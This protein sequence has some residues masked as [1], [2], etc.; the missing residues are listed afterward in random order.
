MIAIAII[1]GLIAVYFGAWQL[2]E[3]ACPFRY[4]S[5]GTAN[6]SIHLKDI[7]LR[8]LSRSTMW[9]TSE[10]DSCRIGVRKRYRH[11]CESILLVI[12]AELQADMPQAPAMHRELLR[13]GYLSWRISLP[14]RV[15]VQCQCRDSLDDLVSIVHCMIGHACSRPE[16]STFTVHARNGVCGYDMAVNG[17]TTWA[18]VLW[19][20][21]R[22]YEPGRPYKWNQLPNSTL[23]STIGKLV[24]IRRSKG[25]RN[26]SC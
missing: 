10:T 21:K 25:K 9:F 16:T 6:V 26:R 17:N 23:L 24:R 5:V 20:R 7:F 3:L 4:A 2:C 22:K 8:G 11:G 13:R 12:T 19:A 18:D 14:S 15:L 1:F